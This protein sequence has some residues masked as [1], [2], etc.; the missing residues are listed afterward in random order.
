M[1]RSI[2]LRPAKELRD[3]LRLPAGAFL[4]LILPF[5]GVKG[6]GDYWYITFKD[7]HIDGLGME[8]I[9]GEHTLPYKIA[10]EAL[11]LIG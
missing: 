2:F 10:Q 7:H 1:I 5:F 8:T 3:A 11:N 6:A 4:E 9:V